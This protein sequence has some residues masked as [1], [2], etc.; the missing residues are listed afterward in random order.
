MRHKGFTLVELIAVIAVLAIILAITVPTIMGVVEMARRNAFKS[1]AKLVVKAIDDKKVQS[2]SFDERTVNKDNISSLL[3]VPSDNYKIVSVERI[4]DNPYLVIVGQ[5]R[6]DDLV[7]CG[8]MNDM[9][10]GHGNECT[11]LPPGP[12]YSDDEIT[13]MI[14]HGYIPIADVTELKNIRYSTTNV[15]GKGSKWEKEYVGGLDKKYVQINNLDLSSESTGEGWI[16]L[17]LNNVDEPAFTGIYD[18]NDYA[19]FNLFINNTR[20]YSGLFGMADGDNVEFKNVS[21]KNVN[22][23]TTGSAGA[24]AGFM[25]HGALVSRVTASGTIT[26]SGTEVGG[27]MGFFVD[28]D[29]VI[30][31]CYANVTVKADDMAG[32][33]IGAN[34][35]SAGIIRNSYAIGSVTAENG[36]AGG[37]I[38][39]SDGRIENVITNGKV[40]GTDSV[41]GIVGQFYGELI[42]DSHAT[43]T[44]TGGS[45]VGGIAGQIYA[46][47]SNSYATGNVTGTD[48]VGGL[49][50]FIANATAGIKNSYATGSVTGTVEYTGGLV[51]EGYVAI[52]N[53]HATGSVVGVNNVG[54]LIGFHSS[55]SNSISNSYSRGNVSG[56]NYVGGLVGQGY[57]NIDNCYTT[58]S[59]NGG[60]YVG[61]LIGYSAGTSINHVYTT[62]SVQGTISEIGGIAGETY[63]DYN[64]VY[65][66]GTVMG[67]DNT[68]GLMGYGGGDVTGSYKIGNVTGND[69]VGGLFGGGT[70]DIIQTYYRGNVI[71]NINVGGFVGGDTGGNHIYK[72]YVNGTVRGVSNLGGIVGYGSGVNI[73][74]SY[75]VNQLT[76]SGDHI[77]GLIGFLNGSQINSSYYANTI[78]G[79]TSD[80]GGL[81]GGPDGNG[82]E[83]SQAYWDTEVSKVATSAKGYLGG[84]IF[85]KTTSEMKQQSTYDGWDF[86]NIWAI[87][88]SVN[89]GYP[90][91]K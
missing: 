17:G 9:A 8:T 35:S 34:Y 72:S 90:Y 6:W 73:D 5:N 64:D 2:A 22:I 29:A 15:F 7:A 58:G 31:K 53:S 61:G 21:F 10:V 37:L 33:L 88:P 52:D 30:D 19:I 4:D 57:E 43:G 81:I 56:G 77:G 86:A 25:Y 67:K 62:G 49:A 89:N 41:G 59:I 74:N 51:G 11:I 85:G 20:D 38:G 69:N 1:D 71:G 83:S 79:G 54:G 26:S 48:D 39:Q 87:S 80:V 47:I 16:P 70:G 40:K 13:S 36:S 50:G 55:S 68:G 84:G 12:L 66:M 18:G 45:T 42:T 27:I 3:E 91:L 60:R 76:A 65:A 82:P 14:D 32:G 63:S 28:E 78:T 44:V 24:M 75:A 23:T 46:D